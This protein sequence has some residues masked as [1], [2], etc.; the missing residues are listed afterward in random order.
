MC[1]SSTIEEIL[2]I[3][4]GLAV[5]SST[6]QSYIT[7]GKIISID[8]QTYGNM[9][10]E[11]EDGNTLYVFGVYDSNGVR[12]D[13]MTNKPAVGDTVTVSSVIKNY[14]GTIE[15]VNATLLSVVKA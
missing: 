6:T 14:N 7:T 13:G 4:S 9:T 2:Q 12:Y 1:K 10:I 3:G 5:G 11:D 8:N 15:F